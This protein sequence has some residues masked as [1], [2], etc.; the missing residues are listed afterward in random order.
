MSSTAIEEQIR[1]VIRLH[2]EAN[3]ELEQRLAAARNALAREWATRVRQALASLER[4][5]LLLAKVYAAPVDDARTRKEFVDHA[6]K[7]FGPAW[8]DN[9]HTLYDFVWAQYPEEPD[10][11]GHE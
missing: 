1:R 10:P 6:L 4:L 8:Y 5:G 11:T 9:L 2:Q 3:D 7:V